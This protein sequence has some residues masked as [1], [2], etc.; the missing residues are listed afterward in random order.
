M[1][2]V[3]FYRKLSVKVLSF[4]C[5]Y[6]SGKPTNAMDTFYIVI[7][8]LCLVRI[9]FLW[10]LLRS[11][12]CCENLLN[13]DWFRFDCHQNYLFWYSITKL[14]ITS[15]FSRFKASYETPT[16]EIYCDEIKILASKRGG[17]QRVKTGSKV[18]CAGRYFTPWNCLSFAYM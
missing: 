5:S 2:W 15:Y 14:H 13:S 16:L 3:D 11:G 17:R 9:L 8:V 7:F 18:N 1:A 6:F 10:F 4:H 12:W